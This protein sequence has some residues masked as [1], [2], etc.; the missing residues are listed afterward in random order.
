[1]L[2]PPDDDAAAP[3]IIWCQ[4]N[5][6]GLLAQLLPREFQ[7]TREFPVTAFNAHTYKQLFA[8]YCKV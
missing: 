8:D 7:E 1:M 6:F 2:N 4:E 5:M 3:V